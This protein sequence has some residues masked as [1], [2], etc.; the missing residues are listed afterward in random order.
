[1][2]E[3]LGADTQRMRAASKELE[4]VYSKMDATTRALVQNLQ[5]L[6]QAMHEHGIQRQLGKLAENLTQADNSIHREL[7]DIGAELHERAT[8]ID[9][10]VAGTQLDLAS[11]ADEIGG[12]SDSAGRYGKALNG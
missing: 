1:M 7:L 3:P 10:A 6:S 12:N 11:A 8:G 9:G 2:T 5:A 4:G